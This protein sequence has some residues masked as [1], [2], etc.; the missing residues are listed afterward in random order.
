MLIIFSCIYWSFVYLHWRYVYPSSLPTFKLNDLLLLSYKSSLYRYSGYWTLK[1]FAET[2]SYSVYS[3]NYLDC[4][5]DLQ[6]FLILMKAI[7]EIAPDMGH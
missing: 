5:I 4:I 6:K 3:L 2:F 7:G 1:R